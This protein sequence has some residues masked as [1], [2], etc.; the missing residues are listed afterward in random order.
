VTQTSEHTYVSLPARVRLAANVGLHLLESVAIPLGVFYGVV[1]AFGLH[2]ALLAALGWGY[3]A[4][5]VRIVRRSRPP[6]LLLVATVTSTV[7]VA[8]TF[9]A[10]SATAYFL[11][12]TV[13]T[14]LFALAML[15]TWGWER[16]L[17]QRLAHDFCPLP[18]RV[19]ASEPLKRF[20]QRLSVLWGAVLLINTGATLVLLLTM[21]TTW[22]V[23]LAAAAS[24]PAFVVGLL[25]SYRWFLRS[26]LDAHC[27]LRWG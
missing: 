24:V 25:V 22:S 16:P 8:I 21:S 14:G 4:V 20:F 9:A 18:D 2:A 6:M 3:L 19:L 27:S 17:I 26:M 12:P 1:I 11:Q 13:I 5:A 23:P 10:N 7:K 15:C